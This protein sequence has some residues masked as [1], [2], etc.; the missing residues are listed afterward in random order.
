MSVGT[1]YTKFNLGSGIT[2]HVEEI[3]FWE[4]RVVTVTFE[5]NSRIYHFNVDLVIEHE[6]ALTIVPILRV[7]QRQ[8][9][10]LL[11]SPTST[12]NQRKDAERVLHGIQCKIA[13]DASVDLK[14]VT[15]DNKIEET[16]VIRDDD[17]RLSVIHEPWK[18]EI[19]VNM[20]ENPYG[21]RPIYRQSG[22][23][24]RSTTS[25][26]KVNKIKSNWNPFA[27]NEPIASNSQD[28]NPFGFG[29]PVTNSYPGEESVVPVTTGLVSTSSNTTIKKIPFGEFRFGE[30]VSRT[31]RNPFEGNAP[32]ATDSNTITTESTTGFGDTIERRNVKLIPN[33]ETGIPPAR[34]GR[35]ATMRSDN[36]FAGNAPIASQ[37]GKRD[38][39]NP[40]AGN[41]P[42]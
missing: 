36:P 28:P 37:Y 26:K 34:F 14:D 41:A 3:G 10:Q 16:D 22:R 38:D 40:F 42:F 18:R 5:N 27:G 2:V 19:H 35:T 9:T 11:N 20:E 24:K 33:P 8:F 39:T 15:V 32:I 6:K 29:K 4:P 31:S 12:E 17:F 1:T 25:S 30:N 13:A 7:L 23:I 21:I